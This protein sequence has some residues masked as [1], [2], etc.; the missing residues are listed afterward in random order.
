M[1][2][3]KVNHVWQGKLK[4]EIG[5]LVMGGQKEKEK[6][7]GKGQG[8]GVRKEDQLEDGLSLV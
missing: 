7:K 2:K 8:E 6:E 4:E 1:S 3:P 5:K